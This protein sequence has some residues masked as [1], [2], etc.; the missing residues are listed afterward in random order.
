MQMS[1]VWRPEYQTSRPI[2]HSFGSTWV[3]GFG[4]VRH[5]LHVNVFENL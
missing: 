5:A 3:W 4:L 1:F 2:D